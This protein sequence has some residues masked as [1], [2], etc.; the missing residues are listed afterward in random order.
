MRGN[1]TRRGKHSWRLKFDVAG[2]GHRRIHYA[3]IRGTRRDAERELARLLHAA[4]TGVLVD[5]SKL[6]VADYL[7]SWLDGA[8][9]LASKTAERYR[10]LVEQQIVPHLGALALQKLRPSHIQ[11]WH[12]KLLASGGKGG[13]P[14][15]PR[16][17][18]HAH[19]VLHRAYERALT[20]ELVARNP[21]HAIHP[22]KVEIHEIASLKAE[23]VAGVL[24]TLAGHSLEPIAILALATG[25]RRGE[26]LALRWSDVDPAAGSMK[27]ER[28]LEQTAAG[29]KFKPPKTKRGTRVLALPPSAI[30]A[31]Q[32]HRKKQLE[33]RLALGQGKPADDT[34]V[35][36]TFD[37]N[38][39]RLIT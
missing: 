27:I 8:H 20:A 34:L 24:A 39:S 22:P 5:P 21:V 16:T 10:Q 37:G 28:S 30:E 9:G 12:Q 25:A 2:A 17:V 26:I 18:G 23:D 7:R 19:R 35:F 4:N 31:L 15:S 6:T 14:L 29:L 13:A 3:T 36:S 33:L 32:A 38:L 11:D 1:V